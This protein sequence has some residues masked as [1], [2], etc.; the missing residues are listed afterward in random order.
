MY[1]TPAV[2]T[3]AAMHQEATQLEQRDLHELREVMLPA[4][5]SPSARQQV[6]IVLA[7]QRERL[8]AR[9]I[10]ELIQ[11]QFPDHLIPTLDEVRE[12][13]KEG[14]EFVQAERYRWSFGRQLMLWVG[15]LRTL[16]GLARASLFDRSGCDPPNATGSP[17][18]AGGRTRPLC[19]GRPSRGRRAERV[20]LYAY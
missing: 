19:S 6:A 2:E 17:G 20:Q 8:L 9:Q 10:H 15:K 4:P 3:L 16:A 12:V 18:A 5:N 7:R 1:V 13:L 14:P 11:R